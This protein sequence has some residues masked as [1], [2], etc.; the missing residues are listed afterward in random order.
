MTERSAILV[1]PYFPPS[2]LAG[3][4]RM[5]HLSKHLPA[6]GWDPTVV[7]IDE[8]YHEER[9]DP[10]LA[11]LVPSHTKVVKVGALPSGITRPLGFGDIGM[12]GFFQIR[13][14][15]LRIAEQRRIDVVLITGSPF[16]PMLMAKTLR[17]AG[18]PVVLDFR[19]PWASDWG[20]AQP[21]FSKVGLSHAIAT[22]LEPRVL[23]QASFV[24]SV[25]EIQN[26]KLAARY[27]WLDKDR[28]AAIPIG[29]DPQDFEPI[30][31]SDSKASNAYLDPKRINLSYVGTFMPRT[32][33]PMRALFRGL[34][35]LKAEL[36]N[37][38]QRL[39]LNFIGTSNQPN[40][41][42][43]YQVMPLATKEGVADLVQEVPQRVP[44]LDALGILV[45]SNGLLLIGSDEIHY[46]A[47]KIY[48]ALMSAT[49]YLS[50]FH[51]KSSAHQILSS[52]GGGLAFSFDGAD[53]LAKL[54]P[55]L[56]RSLEQLAFNPGSI[57]QAD[58]TA[59]APYEA[60]AAARR[61]ADVFERA[62]RPMG[63]TAQD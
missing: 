10:A 21:T 3:V 42:D 27:P 47:S 51:N 16:Y 4:H 11:M 6:A 37:L 12:R 34:R 33:E 39:R 62:I 56:A 50:I 36:P 7:C 45:N 63:V 28:M 18:I 40:D 46:T 24:T 52:V 5:R 8:K 55:A 30:R 26:A 49:P 32:T 54:A 13:S 9:L 59:Y 38:A 35:L 53:E 48:P 44:Y 2:T 15:I 14:A 29:I 58:A 19:D 31:R 17:R 25:S 57:G 20:E 43:T 41:T 61:F 1:A 22:K 23:R 60:S